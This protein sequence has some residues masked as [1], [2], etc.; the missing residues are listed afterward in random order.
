MPPGAKGVTMVTVRSG[1]AAWAELAATVDATRIIH[2]IARNM[3]APCGWSRCWDAC[4]SKH[5]SCQRT[6]SFAGITA[7]GRAAG[8]PAGG[9]AQ[10]CAARNAGHLDEL[11]VE[12][13][14]HR[15]DGAG[16][17]RRDLKAAGQLDLHLSA[18]AELEN[19]A[20]FAV[21]LAVEPLGHRLQ[22]GLIA[23]EDPQTLLQ[24]R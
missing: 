22:W 3:M 16:D 9:A 7:R 20:D 15:L 2:A 18:A 10:G 11:Y 4:Q 6:V 12:H 14:G 19:H 1:H 13:A 23:K 24:L 8:Q 17:L 5:A 21:A